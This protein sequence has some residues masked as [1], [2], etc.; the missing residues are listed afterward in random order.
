MFHTMTDAARFSPRLGDPRPT[1]AQLED[2]AKSP[3]RFAARLGR[4]T[5]RAEPCAKE[6]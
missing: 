2:E 3:D 4:L 6:S 1:A 5:R